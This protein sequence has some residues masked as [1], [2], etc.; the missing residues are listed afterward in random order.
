[1]NVLEQMNRP[2][3]CKVRLTKDCHA[4]KAGSVIEYSSFRADQM[5]EAGYGEIVKDAPVSDLTDT[6]AKRGP[7]RPPKIRPENKSVGA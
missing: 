4:G 6:P 3:F 7:G 5:V 1:M 2:A